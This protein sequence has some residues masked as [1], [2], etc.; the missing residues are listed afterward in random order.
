MIISQQSTNWMLNLDSWKSQMTFSQFI[1]LKPD[2]ASP[3]ASLYND[4]I[5]FDIK[6]DIP[7]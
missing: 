4:K 3:Q 6:L 1:D 2:I 7:L 5:S